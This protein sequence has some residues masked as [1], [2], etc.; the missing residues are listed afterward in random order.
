MKNYH[1]ENLISKKYIHLFNINLKEF[2]IPIFLGADFS[3]SLP[4]KPP[5]FKIPQHLPRWKIIN[6]QQ[7]Q[8]E[9]KMDSMKWGPK[10]ISLASLWQN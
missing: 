1:K 7:G 4:R 3:N 6:F 8:N 2:L 5:T 9:R 10:L